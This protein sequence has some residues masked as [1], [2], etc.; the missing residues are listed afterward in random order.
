MKRSRS[1]ASCV[2][3]LRRARTACRWRARS[4]RRRRATRNSGGHRAEHLLAVRGRVRRDVGQH[5]RR[6]EVARAG[7]AR[8]PPVS[9]RAPAA[10]DA[11]HLR[12]ESP[13]SSARRQRADLRVGSSIG[14]PT[15]SAA[16]PRAR[17]AA[18]T[19]RRSPRATMKRLAAMQD[20]PLLIVR[21]VDRRLA[22]PRRGRRSA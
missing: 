10:T 21:A 9:T 8:W 3:T 13:R 11:P 19:R 20:W 6:V 22:P 17:S 15:C 1:A 18:R 16:I 14:S 4:P 5:G 2:H 12:V 7:R